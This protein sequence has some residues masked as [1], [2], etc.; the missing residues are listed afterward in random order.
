MESKSIS[1]GSHL[2][3]ANNV[4]YFYQISRL[5]DSNYMIIRCSYNGEAKFL[6]MET[7]NI[8]KRIKCG[9]PGRR[10]TIS[11]YFVIPMNPLIVFKK[12][13]NATISFVHY[14]NNYIHHPIKPG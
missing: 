4:T 12:V 9:R 7:E 14:K 8:V 10:L 1:T 13:N 6:D 2:A 11:I 3:N 5:A